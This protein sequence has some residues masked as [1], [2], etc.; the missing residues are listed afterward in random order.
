LLRAPGS[1]FQQN[2]AGKISNL[3]TLRVVNKTSLDLPIEL[4]LENREGSLRVMGAETLIVPAEKLA[5]TSVLIELDRANLQG[6]S[7]PVLVGVYS[8]GRRIETVKTMF[9][10]PRN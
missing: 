3:Y 4:K 10:G 1:L 8:G 6:A 2:A 9:V 5:Q 7:T